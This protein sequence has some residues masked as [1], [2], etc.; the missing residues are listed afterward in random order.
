M[1]S[2]PPI[3]I[4]LP[5]PAVAVQAQRLDRGRLTAVVALAG[6]AAPDS[7]LSLAAGCGE[8]S[9]D[10]MT[11]ANA[12]GRWRTLMR[13]TTPPGR[14]KVLVRISYWPRAA[15]QS[16]RRVRVALRR[17]A[18][19]GAAVRPRPPP[20]GAGAGGAGGGRGP[21]PRPAPAG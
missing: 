16:S 7:Q 11:Y 3:A 13:L 15:A 21:P 8:L 2:R 19:A 17:S 20:A 6:R 14:R 5:K 18:T 1:P 9:C 4:D 10:G 12:A